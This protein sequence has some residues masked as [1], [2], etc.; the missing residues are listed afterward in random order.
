MYRFT[1]TGVQCGPWKEKTEIAVVRVWAVTLSRQHLLQV[2]KNMKMFC[3]YVPPCNMFC[4]Q[5]IYYLLVS[6]WD[7][8][9]IPSN[10]SREDPYVGFFVG[11]R[12]HFQDLRNEKPIEIPRYQVT[13]H[14]KGT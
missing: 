5:S 11:L 10:I 9:L 6:S 3:F 8:S 2:Y 4:A 7:D 12:I 14:I 13:F 1:V